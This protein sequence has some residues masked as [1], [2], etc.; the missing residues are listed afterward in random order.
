ML[1][2]GLPLDINN[3]TSGNLFSLLISSCFMTF[4][5]SLATIVAHAAFALRRSKNLLPESGMLTLK[6]TNNHLL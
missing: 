3:V 6:S 5:V 2:H 1:A 4:F